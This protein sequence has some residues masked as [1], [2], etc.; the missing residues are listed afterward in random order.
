MV[1]LVNQPIKNGGQGLPGYKLYIYIL[2]YI[3][4]YYIIYYI[5]LYYI[6]LYYI[7]L[8]YIILYYII[9]YYIILYYIIL[10]YIILYYII[11][12]YIILYILPSKGW[13]LNYLPG[14]L[15]NRYPNSHL[16]YSPQPTGVPVSRRKKGKEGTDGPWFHRP[17]GRP[18]QQS[19]GYP[20]WQA[21]NF[22]SPHH[23]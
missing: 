7:I 11:L 9:L 3:I 5:I 17:T 8:Y 2:Y 13:C 16:P 20:Q 19:Q 10:Y 22:R 1:K 23:L 14:N 15:L 21:S 6:I 4:L 12:Y 18:T